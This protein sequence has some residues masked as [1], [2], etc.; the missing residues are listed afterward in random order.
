MDSWLSHM[1]K[2]MLLKS[3]G[4]SCNIY[5]P[6]GDFSLRAFCAERGIAYADSGLPVSLDTFSAYGLAFRD[7][8]VPEVEDK[9]VTSLEQTS[10]GFALELEDGETVTARRVVLAVGLTHFRYVPECLA[11]LP[12]RFFSHSFNHRDL[13]PFRGRNV[14]VIGGGASAI[15]LAGLL[16][17]YDADVRLVARKPALQ[18]HTSPQDATS[19]WYQATHPQSGIGSGVKLRFYA[20]AP[21]WFHYLPERTRL[22]IVRT[23]LGPSGGWFAKDKL[24]GRVPLSLGCTP[25]GADIENDHV[26]LH[27]RNG[28]GND[29]QIATEH[30]IAATGYRVDLSRLKFL[31]PDLSSKLKSVD[32]TP[33][34]SSGFESSIPGLYF[35]GAAA[36]NS[37]GPV[38]RF[39]FGAGFAARTVSQAMAKSLARKESSTPVRDRVDSQ[40][41]NAGKIAQ[42]AGTLPAPADGSNG[43][44]RPEPAVYSEPLPRKI[45]AVSGK[46][47]SDCSPLPHS[48]G[49]IGD[50]L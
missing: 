48:T 9:L 5:D 39:A 41:G 50:Q 16:R 21:M 22:N 6:D 33:V 49:S 38:L 37:F 15:D 46:R 34:L 26:R 13:E 4:F 3:D 27:L 35:V 42:E 24:V 25:T 28:D 20:D 19:W 2:G 12:A 8:M 18:F 43:K 7:R 23:S 31:R 1:P 45:R 30:I 14:V 36:A 44:K 47:L 10:Q 29:H 17:D 40:N 32:G 11:H